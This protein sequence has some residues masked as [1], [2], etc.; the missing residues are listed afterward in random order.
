MTSL[1]TPNGFQLFLQEDSRIR[2]RGGDTIGVQY[3]MCATDSESDLKQIEQRL[4]PYD[5]A[6]FSYI[7][8]GVNFV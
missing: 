5:V 6:A 7:Q 3:L 4:R 2:H 1:L 8:G